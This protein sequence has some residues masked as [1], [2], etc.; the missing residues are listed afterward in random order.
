MPLVE[1]VF[2]PQLRNKPLVVLSNNDGCVIASNEAKALGI[3]VGEPAAKIKA[4][5]RNIKSM[6]SL[7]TLLYGDLSDEVMNFVKS[8][9][10]KVEI[11]SIDESLFSF[12]ELSTIDRVVSIKKKV[13]Q[14][15]GIPVSF[16][17]RTN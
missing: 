15:T 4:L 2:N 1:R 5:L 10:E 16:G 17:T 7:R 8:E 14:W 11:Y 12:S 3:K 9:I 6:Y 13:Q